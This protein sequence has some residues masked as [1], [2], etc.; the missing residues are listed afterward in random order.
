MIVFVIA[1]VLRQIDV[2]LRIVVVLP[3]L[4][5]LYLLALGVALFLSALF[6]QYHDVGHLWDVLMQLLFYGS[7]VMFSLTYVLTTSGSWS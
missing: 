2:S 6:V 3:L 1:V 4:I 5:E 7:G